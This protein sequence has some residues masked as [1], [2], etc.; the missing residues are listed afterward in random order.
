M[1][2][3]KCERCGCFF[4]SDGNVC[5]S[6]APKDN[7]EMSKLNNYFIENKQPI[8]VNDLSYATGISKKNLTR[9]ISGKN[10]NYK[11]QIE[12]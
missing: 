8:T 7:Y 12:L 6:C 2:F 5:P 1:N 11:K 3:N 10:F 4:V 9:F